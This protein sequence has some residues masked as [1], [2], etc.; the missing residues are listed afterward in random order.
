VA[1]TI[2]LHIP[3]LL[4]GV[5]MKAGG[6]AQ[7]LLDMVKALGSVLSTTK[8][9]HWDFVVCFKYFFFSLILFTCSQPA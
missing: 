1:P 6:R 3:F 9:W 8:E 4:V 2:T 7:L 5:G